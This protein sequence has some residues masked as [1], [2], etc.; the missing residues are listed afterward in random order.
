[1]SVFLLM[2]MYA[3]MATAALGIEWL[4]RAVHLVP[5]EHHAKVVESAITLNYTTALNGIFLVISGL[6]LMR[7]LRTAGPEML[8]MMR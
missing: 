1:M 5:P 8:R 2:T 7:F 4:F 3:S 6:L